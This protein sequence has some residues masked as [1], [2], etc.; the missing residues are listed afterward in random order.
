MVFYKA[1]PERLRALGATVEV[2]A[3]TLLVQLPKS[4]S[5]TDLVRCGLLIERASMFGY[6]DVRVCEAGEYIKIEA[7]SD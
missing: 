4:T 3:R 6:S 7:E 1:D 5:P 2:P